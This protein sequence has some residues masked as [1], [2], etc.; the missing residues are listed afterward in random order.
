MISGCGLHR[1]K[2]SCEVPRLGITV[3]KKVSKKAVTRNLLKREIREFYRAHQCQLFTADLVITAR[4]T[5]AKADKAE[6]HQSLQQL[7]SKVLKWQR[8]RDATDK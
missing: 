1:D 7:W 6:R 2:L 8:W 5:C 3:S 4:P